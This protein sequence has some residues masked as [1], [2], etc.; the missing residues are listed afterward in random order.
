MIHLEIRVKKIGAG[1]LEEG[2]EDGHEAD[3]DE[4]VHSR[5]VPDLDETL[6]YIIVHLIEDRKEHCFF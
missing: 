3:H 6:G 2:R 5:R 4:R 1:K